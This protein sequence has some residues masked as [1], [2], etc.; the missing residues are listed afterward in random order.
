MANEIKMDIKAG[1]NAKAHTSNHSR[2]FRYATLG[3]SVVIPNDNVVAL[4]R[5]M[6]AMRDKVTRD[7]VS[8]LFA[9]GCR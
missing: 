3:P 9:M 6:I 7:N 8:A 4:A 1:T 5:L 2:A